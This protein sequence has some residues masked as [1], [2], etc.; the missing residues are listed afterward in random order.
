MTE[1]LIDAP[2][3]G[4]LSYPDE[5]PD[6]AIAADLSNLFK[7]RQA[8]IDAGLDLFKQLHPDT[9]QMASM[10]SAQAPEPEAPAAPP[11]LREASRPGALTGPLLPQGT[12]SGIEPGVLLRSLASAFKA[13]PK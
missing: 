10:A 7:E 1:Q 3:L 11:E 5:M 4:T 8:R 13:P 6:A 2:A 9:S 12:A